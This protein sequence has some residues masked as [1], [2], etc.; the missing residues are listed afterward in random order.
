MGGKGARFGIRRSGEFVVED[1]NRAQPFAS[2]FPGIAGE[3]GVPMWVF[4]VNRGQCVCSAGVEDKD[5][6]ALEF[7]SANR[8]YEVVAVEGFRTFVRVDGGREVWEPFSPEG[9]GR[10]GIRQELKIRPEEIV[11]V[12]ENRALGLAMEV[13]FFTVA[14]EGFPGLLRWVRIKNL[15]RSVREVEVLDGAALV[16]PYGVDNRNVKLMR[17][18]VESFVEV[19]NYG[20]GYTPMFKCRVR[21]E[22]TPDVR[23]VE[24][25]HFYV[26]FAENGRGL[27]VIVDPVAVFGTRVD[28]RVPE[29]FAGGARFRFPRDQILENR[30]PCAFALVRLRLRAGEEKGWY[31]VLG[32]CGSAGE[33]KEIRGRIGRRDFV[34]NKREA[35]RRVIREVMDHNWIKSACRELDLYTRQNFLDNILRGGI[36]VSLTAGDGTATVIH[37]F[38]R[39]HGDLER[40]YNDFR[41]TP[42]P[43]SQGNGNYRDVNQNRR[44]DL[45]FNPDVGADNVRHFYNLIQLDGFN[46]LV[47]KPTSFRVRDGDR[48]SRVLRDR[49][50]AALVPEIES[51]LEKR[52]LPGDLVLSL[53]RLGAGWTS[54]EERSFLADVLACCEKYEETDYG[55][56]F[57]TDHW[58]YN[59]DLLENFLAV[60]PERLREILLEDRSFT[61]FNNP[62]R[63]QPRREKYVLWE[64]R[65]M[66]LGAVVWDEEKAALISRYT[67]SPYEVRTRWG[68]GQ[69]Y[70]TILLNKLLCLVVN[71]LASL[72][73]SGV[74][75]EMEADKPNW[76]D[77]LNGLPGLFG[78]SISE[79][80]E[81]KRHIRFLLDAFRRMG[82]RDTDRFDTFVELRTFMAEVT[83]L[84]RRHMGRNADRPLD[85][86][87]FWDEASTAKER[88]REQIRMGI[89]GE[90]VAVSFGEIREFL[91]LGLEKVERGIRKAWD[92]KIGLPRTYFV[93]EV[94]EYE[95]ERFEEGDSQAV[96]SDTRGMP[97][98]RPLKFRRRPLPLFLEGIVHYLRICDDRNAA[99]RIYAA[100]RR[101]GLYDRQLKM[102]KV[103]ESLADEPL[104]IGRTR[105]FSRGWLENESIWLHMEYKYMLE[106]LRRGCIE[107]FYA[108]FEK[109]FVPFMSPAVYGRSILE[110]SSFIASSANPDR[111]VHGRGFVA[112]LSGST[113]EFIHIMMTMALGERPFQYDGRDLLFVPRPSLHQRL[114]TR[115]PGRVT[116]HLGG[117][118]RLESIPS[119]SFAFVFLGSVLICYR[120][121]A[122]RSTFGPRAVKP[123][124]FEVR[125]S[126]GK[127]RRIE[128]G[129]LKGSDARKLRNREFTRVDIYLE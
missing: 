10:S 54:A 16:V 34:V 49:L 97:H 103:N 102:Y 4:Y 3:A 13:V 78:S 109:V 80:L 74:G 31:G 36:P 58:T 75:V 44:C 56:G 48:L 38:S 68:D 93:H 20:E 83:D 32:N 52:F 55:Q 108:D 116:L 126:D 105:T 115:R 76:Y 107:E 28:L 25:G 90:E 67:D 124:R 26:A 5:S 57:W 59:L 43:Y 96:R 95:E 123:V 37:L 94:V 60:F 45:F 129:I 119:A 1:Y 22:D 65:P 6:A 91:E 33:L 62:F 73:P 98:F 53:R 106:L 110:N 66:Q 8:A 2:F 121:A 21:Q 41:L 42:T 24:R 111:T 99:R 11:L 27:R 63:V 84:L 122:G 101:S 18:L 114:F 47:V 72:D 23:R 71:K 79:T 15:R 77:A 81:I 92:R 118:E 30:L 70:R 7:H 120:N 82:I 87:R 17:R 12:E 9:A 125:E 112:R 69:I 89:S 19:A 29:R 40:D 50:P 113:A 100:V 64:G 88:Y 127:Q 14:E 128:G 85:D 39:K 117:E 51:R 61:F 104:E 46:P 35:N 86:F